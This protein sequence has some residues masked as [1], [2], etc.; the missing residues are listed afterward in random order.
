MAPNM[1]SWLGAQLAPSQ[2]LEPKGFCLL[3]F[4][5]ADGGRVLAR[6]S[7]TEP[8]VKFYFEVKAPLAEGEPLAA[9]ETRAAT[10]LAELEA[11]FLGL[12]GV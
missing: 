5:L 9:V 7:G 3:A 6:P 10:R 1:T 12:A 2:L 8:K 4:D 11:A